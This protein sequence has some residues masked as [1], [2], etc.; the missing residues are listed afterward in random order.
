MTESRR[1]QA[2]ARAGVAGEQ[3]GR[4][5]LAWALGGCRILSRLCVVAC[6]LALV[7]AVL[8][9]NGIRAAPQNGVP[10]QD[11]NSVP[12]ATQ[13]EGHGDGI[14][15]AGAN[16]REETSNS[17]ATGALDA[18]SD[19]VAPEVSAAPP[20]PLR[21]AVV[22]LDRVF[23]QSMEWRNYEEQRTQLMDT[24]R[25]SLSHYDRQVRVL[26]D[27]YA[28]L[29]PG[30]AEAAEKQREVEAAVEEWRAAE[31]QFN[32]QLGAQHS[33]S[34][35]TMLDRISTVL[36]AYAEA[37]N[38]DLVLKK[39]NLRVSAAMQAEMGI[40]AA[41]TDVLYVSEQ[42]DVTEPVVKQLNAEFEQG[43]ILSP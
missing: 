30:T 26:R 17:A 39:Q 35:S 27:E 15:V 37:H 1:S 21:L 22:D 25:R 6:A 4:G 13:D 29:P 19:A 38:I 10:R 9:G 31:D 33:K 34:L 20:E 16:V 32:Q 43:L 42:F 40:I 7:G 11:A 36:E 41:T 3:A 5:N 24:I 12:L 28:D 18:S 23:E 14:G 8:T 2:K